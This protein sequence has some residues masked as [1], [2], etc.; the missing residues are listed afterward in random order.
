MNYTNQMNFSSE[1]LHATVK[2]LH[3]FFFSDHENCYCVTI[4]FVVELS[5]YGTFVCLAP[6][7]PIKDHVL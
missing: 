4:Q 3:F 5:K 6:Q 2:N 1:I 7:F